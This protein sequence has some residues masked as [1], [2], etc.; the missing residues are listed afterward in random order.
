MILLILASCTTVSDPAA[1]GGDDGGAVT[2][3]IRD[4]VSSA[5]EKRLERADLEEALDSSYLVYSEYIPS[6]DDIKNRYLSSL[7]TI[8]SEGMDE[9][10]SSTVLP[11]GEEIGNNPSPYLS[12]ELVTPSLEAATGEILIENLTQYLDARSGEL[13]EAF[14][15]SRDTFSR[16]KKAYA[17]LSA[18][19]KGVVIP[20][21]ETASTRALASAAARRYFSFLG[22]EE[23]KKRSNPLYGG[24]SL[25]LEN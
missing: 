2:T 13:E 5:G 23:R 6:Y 15:E 8:V 11:A 22:E 3:L 16:V 25:Y 10:F 19:S 7:L 12:G 20:Q 9:I 18:V 14:A 4:I 24:R 17:A 1:S 21:A